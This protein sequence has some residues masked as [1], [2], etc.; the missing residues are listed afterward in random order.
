VDYFEDDAAEFKG[1]IPVAVDLAEQRLAREIDSQHLRINTVVS[2]SAGD[3]YI[4]KPDGYKFA[5]N[6][7]LTKTNGELKTLF[8]T[9]DS[10]CED[11]WP[12]IEASVAEPKYYADYGNRQFVLAPTPND[13]APLLLSYSGRPTRLT[14]TASVN[15]FTSAFSDLLFAATLIEQAKFA[16]HNGMVKTLEDHYQLRLQSVVNEGRRERRD[17]GI[18]PHNSAS[19]RNTLNGPIQPA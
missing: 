2:C 14:A 8:K 4:N 12:W 13:N 19:H 1:Y 6:L 10:Y 7:R 9:T 17:E 16:R 15:V 3:R 11:Y 5:F 18:E